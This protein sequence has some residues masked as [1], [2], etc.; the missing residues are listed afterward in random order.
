MLNG[1]ITKGIGGF[2]YI[3]T[4]EGVYECRARGKFRKEGIK[5]TVGDHVQISVLDEKNK[6]AALILSRRGKTVL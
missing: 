6:K 5:P 2:Y 3:A 4:S 1:T